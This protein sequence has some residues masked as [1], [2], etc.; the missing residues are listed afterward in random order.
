MVAFVTVFALCAVF[1]WPGATAR[2]AFDAP[3]VG[4]AGGRA[5]PSPADYRASYAK[6]YAGGEAPG[7]CPTVFDNGQDHR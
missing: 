5:P 3:A 4:G 6:R 1:F 2:S 7:T